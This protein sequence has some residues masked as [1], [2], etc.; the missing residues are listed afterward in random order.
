[1]WIEIDQCTGETLPWR[2]FLL[3]RVWKPIRRRRLHGTR[4]T[5]IL[6]EGLLAQIWTKM[7]G[8]WRLYV[9]RVFECIRRWL[10]QGLFCV[11]GECSY[12]WW[13]SFL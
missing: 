1:L 8:M 4:W 6:R 9:W 12:F 7:Y 13:T 3:P 2:A 11:Y 5:P 10:A